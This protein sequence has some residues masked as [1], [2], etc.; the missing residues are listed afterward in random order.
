MVFGSKKKLITMV[1]FMSMALFAVASCSSDGGSDLPGEGVTVQPARATWDTGYFNEALY[2]RGLEDLGYT[3]KDHVEIDNPLFYQQVALGDVDFWANGW[4]PA[5]DQYSEFF[6]GKAEIV[7]TVIPLG[8]IEGYLV[9]KAGAEEFGIKDLGDFSDPAIAAAYDTDG[10]GKA[11][12][13]G[14]PSGWGCTNIQAHHLDDLGLSDFIDHG[15]VDYNVAMADLIARYNTGEHVLFY[16]WTPNWTV[17]VL[18]P[19][20]DVVWIGVPRFSSP[21]EITEAD[22]THSGMIGAVSDPLLSGWSASDIQVVANSEFLAD[23]PS[24]KKLFEVMRLE[25]STVAQQNN[26]MNQGE[27]SQADIERH[28]DEWI[29]ANQATW[30]SWIEAGKKAG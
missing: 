30:D 16:T 22:T 12:L 27:K 1:G 13:V 21:L 17:D 29:A 15:T 8:G 18:A 9:D 20:K 28:V 24:A 23:N 10:N 3:V 19:G 4:F 11:N 26:K 7:G 25:L 2:S 5:H 14:C 6:E